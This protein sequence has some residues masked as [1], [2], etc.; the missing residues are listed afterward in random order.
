VVLYAAVRCWGFDH[1]LA[2]R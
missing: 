1:F 2:A